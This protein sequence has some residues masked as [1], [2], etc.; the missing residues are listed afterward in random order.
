MAT[1][2]A[3][4]HRMSD[5]ELRV[6]RSKKLAKLDKII[7]LNGYFAK[8]DKQALYDQIIAIEAELESR[9]LQMRL[10]S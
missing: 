1:P 3:I 7:N 10:F 8:R 6:L 9:T 4:Y 2:R 5:K